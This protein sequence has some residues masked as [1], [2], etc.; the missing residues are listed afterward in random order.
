MAQAKFD[1]T[2]DPSTRPTASGDHD[3][4]CAARGCPNRWSVQRE[5]GRGMCSAHAWVEDAHLWPV[6]TQEQLDAAADR[7]RYRDA[8]AD[9]PRPATLAMAEK[10]EILQRLA[11]IGTA[12]P[13]AW[14]KRL[15]ARGRAGE[16]LSQA[17]RDC[18]RSYEA[19]MGARRGST[20]PDDY[21]ASMTDIGERQR[22]AAEMTERY[23]ALHPDPPD[24]D[25][26]PTRGRT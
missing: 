8:M 25:R 10:V 2:K 13:H 20:I 18:L 26:P 4:M 6:I 19:F 22:V 12:D 15:Q 17:Q 11:S 23:Q 5:G 14:A 3:L 16:A 21:S 24:M 1:S 7:A 9:R